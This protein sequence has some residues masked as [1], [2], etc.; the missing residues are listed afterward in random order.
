MFSQEKE[1]S[2]LK[3][4]T[5]VINLRARDFNFKPCIVNKNSHINKSILL[6]FETQLDKVFL[7]LFH[8]EQS[9]QH[10]HQDEKCTFC[11]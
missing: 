8:P 4:L 9:F 7:E 3:I 10:H 1:L 5:G 11:H 6:D 2:K